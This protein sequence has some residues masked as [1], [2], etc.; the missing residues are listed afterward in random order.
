[1]ELIILNE[2]GN[3]QIP[4]TIRQQL[5]LHNQ[6]KLA[7]E[8]ENGKLILSPIKDEPNL[9]YEGHVLVADTNLL[10]DVNTVI[11]NIR[12]SRD[13]QFYYGENTI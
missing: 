4:E 12:N 5:G 13:G 7:L 6:S 9:Y 10:E 3:L 1:M 2:S 8:I 11:E